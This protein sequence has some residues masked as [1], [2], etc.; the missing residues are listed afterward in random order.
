MLLLVAVIL[1]AGVIRVAQ[2]QSGHCIRAPCRR[3]APLHCPLAAGE[4]CK[5]QIEYFS[6]MMQQLET[7]TR[8]APVPSTTSYSQTIL[9]MANPVP[10]IGPRENIS[11]TPSSSTL[12]STWCARSPRTAL[13]LRVLFSLEL[14]SKM[15]IVA[16]FSRL[17]RI[18]AKHQTNS[19]KILWDE[20]HNFLAWSTS[21][22]NF[23]TTLE[24]R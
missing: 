14:S 18:L 2:P 11:R 21:I 6:P 15:Q 10:A 16:R 7:W 17:P 13:L 9:S 4:L 5:V 1:L 20:K 3:Y 12:S 8:T 19:E 23:I 22:K 24:T